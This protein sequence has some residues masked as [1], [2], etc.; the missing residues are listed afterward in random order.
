[1]KF[2]KQFLNY[3]I[4]SSA[5]IVAVIFLSG[6][7]QNKKKMNNFIEQS[8]YRDDKNLTNKYMQ[9]LNLKLKNEELRVFQLQQ[10]VQR[11]SELKAMS[12]KNQNEDWSKVN[13]EKQIQKQ[14][15]LPVSDSISNS[16]DRKFSNISLNKDNA[17][18][19]IEMA[20]KN[21]YFVELSETFEIISIT[22]II[23]SQKMNDSFE[24][25]APQ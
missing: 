7:F 3:A 14:E 25:Q 1:M 2:S 9:D 5:V 22:P 15:R 20:R 13:V 8:S 19:F 6:F 16:A 23:Q 18:E 10:Q 4:V 12:K 21:G 11:E 17:Q 24:I